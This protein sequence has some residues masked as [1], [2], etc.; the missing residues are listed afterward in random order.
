MIIYEYRLVFKEYYDN[1]KMLEMIID[2]FFIL[3][4]TLSFF[5][6]KKNCKTLKQTAF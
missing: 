3:D 4:I 5:K 6:M 1:V 2:V